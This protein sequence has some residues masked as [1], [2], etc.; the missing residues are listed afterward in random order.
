MRA[1]REQRL[2][3]AGDH[4]G[5]DETDIIGLDEPVQ[6]YFRAAIAP[7]TPRSRATSLRMRGSIKFGHRWVPFRA[8][9]VLAPLDG[10]HWRAKVA[11]GLLSG[12]DTCLD[13]DATM[14]WKLLGLVP[15]IHTAGSDVTKSA[16]GRAAIEAIWLPTALLPRYDVAWRAEDEEHLVANLSI[17]QQDVTLQ[18]TVDGDGHVSSA[19]LDR[20]HDQYGTGRFEWVPFGVE[21]T[22][23][24]T[25]PCGLTI[26]ADG[27]GGWFHRTDCWSE[28]EFMRYS[29]DDVVL[30]VT[31]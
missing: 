17:R 19:H 31:S 14:L 7:G 13:G 29:I 30:D 27:R 18:L 4:G 10:Y 6:R 1:T 9:E 20:W 2:A 25:F 3:V 15:V 11:G 26:P 21:A 22:A 23:S 5:F 24:R 12:S 8:D 28:G 16:I